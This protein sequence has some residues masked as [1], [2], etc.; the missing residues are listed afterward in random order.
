MK[1]DI[2]IIVAD[3]WILIQHAGTLMLELHIKKPL[4]YSIIF[5]VRH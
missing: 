1:F 4:I 3:S 5:V 2:V